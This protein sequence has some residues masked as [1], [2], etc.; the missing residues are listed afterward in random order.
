MIWYLAIGFLGSVAG[1]VLIYRDEPKMEPMLLGILGLAIIATWPLCLLGAASY[2][3][4]KLVL[5]YMD[6]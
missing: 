5:R 6:R 1:V 3:T 4:A 2:G